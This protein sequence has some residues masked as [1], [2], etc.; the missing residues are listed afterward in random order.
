[1]VGLSLSLHAEFGQIAI[2]KTHPTLRRLVSV[3][4]GIFRQERARR[5]RRAQEAQVPSTPRYQGASRDQK[6][7]K[8]DKHAAAARDLP[9]PRPRNPGRAQLVHEHSPHGDRR[10]A[11]SRRAVH[12]RPAQRQQPV[13][14]PRTPQDYLCPGYEGRAGGA[15]GGANV[16]P[17]ARAIGIL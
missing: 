12:R 6:D 13:R 3:G 17:R 2:G 10:T 14:D 15:R 4:S 16:E 7:A 5:R 1:M 11:A 9:A 8:V